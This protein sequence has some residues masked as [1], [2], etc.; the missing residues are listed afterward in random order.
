MRSRL[1]ATLFCIALAIV[2]GLASGQGVAQAQPAVDLLALSRIDTLAAS[3]PE[4][5]LE[6]IDR[7]LAGPAT[8]ASADPRVLFDLQRLAGDIL[9]RQRRWAEA[10]GVFEVAERFAQRHR[11]VLE[12]DHE[13][14]WARSDEGAAGCGADEGQ[15][16]L[17]ER[18]LRHLTTGRTVDI[19]DRVPLGGAQTGVRLTY[20][21]GPDEKIFREIRCL[22]ASGGLQKGRL[23]LMGVIRDDG[24]PLHRLSFIRLRRQL[25]LD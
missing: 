13:Q 16:A 2:G 5:A 22:F 18:V 14:M 23:R 24:K 17:C 12:A 25:N 4:Q 6:E 1:R 8:G 9:T 20:R 15:V 19:I 10:G 11:E 7:L 3:E 21:D